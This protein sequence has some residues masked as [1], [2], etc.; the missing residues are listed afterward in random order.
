VTTSTGEHGR[1]GDRAAT[2]ERPQI[3]KAWTGAEKKAVGVQGPRG[4]IAFFIR[5]TA[6]RGQPSAGGERETPERDEQGARRKR[7][8]AT[9]ALECRVGCNAT[10]AHTRS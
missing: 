6:M 10:R 5:L 8:A 2:S 7:C 1:D 9:A 3:S 4:F